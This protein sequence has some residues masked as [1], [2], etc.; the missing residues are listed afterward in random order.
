LRQHV[1]ERHTDATRAGL[2]V[3]VQRGVAAWMEVWPRL[4]VSAVRPA[5]GHAARLRPA[6]VLADTSRAVVYVL[7]AMALEQLQEVAR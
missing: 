3:L 4:P 6:P 1:V 7:A 2:S 5:P